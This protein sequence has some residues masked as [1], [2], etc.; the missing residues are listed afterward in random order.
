LDVGSI[1]W[2]EI[3]LRTLPLGCSD[4]CPR[5]GIELLKYLSQNLAGYRGTDSGRIV[6]LDAY[7]THLGARF[8]YRFDDEV[9]DDNLRQRID[10][11]GAV[12]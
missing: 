5:G 12:R 8:G 3:S 6:V 7:C 11:V 2:R 9:I 10:G 1:W 4:E